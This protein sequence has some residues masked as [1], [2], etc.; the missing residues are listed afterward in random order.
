MFCPPCD[1]GEAPRYRLGES[2]FETVNVHAVRSVLF[3][4]V[5]GHLTIEYQAGGGGLLSEAR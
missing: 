2:E 4:S 3:N 5:S 1:L